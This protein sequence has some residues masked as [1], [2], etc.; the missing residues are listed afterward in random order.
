MNPSHK[1]GRMDL[2]SEFQRIR[3]LL[4]V[5]QFTGSQSASLDRVCPQTSNEKLI[6]CAI[7]L[8]D[9]KNTH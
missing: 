1:Q 3:R 2:F 6:L 4:E 5:P 7:N 9:N 8:D